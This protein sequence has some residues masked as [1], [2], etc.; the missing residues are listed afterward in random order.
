MN[1]R[2]STVYVNNVY[3]IGSLSEKISDTINSYAE[4]GYELVSCNISFEDVC[5]ILI[6]KNNVKTKV[7]TNI[8]E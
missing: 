2:Y 5:A 4:C 3:T 8:V 6:F 1:N 7:A